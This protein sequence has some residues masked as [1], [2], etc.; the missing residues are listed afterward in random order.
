MSKLKLR[1]DDEVMV[2]AGKDKDKTG[3]VLKVYP[4][5]G[6]AIIEGINRVKKHTKPNRKDQHGGIKEE[7]RPMQISNLMVVCPS[8]K[9]RVRVG[10]KQLDSGE[11]V[12]FC[13]KCNA[14]MD[15]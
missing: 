9:K 5:I 11:R 1:K 3:K 10:I 13:K 15:K 4:V 7:E 8:C 12:R 2:I 14:V 6:K